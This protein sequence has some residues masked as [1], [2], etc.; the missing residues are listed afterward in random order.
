ME[1]Q[2]KTKEEIGRMIIAEMKTFANC[3]N[4]LGVIVVPISHHTHTANWTVARFNAGRSDTEACD[5]ALQVIVPRF[6]LAYGVVQ[7]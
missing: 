1:K 7:S 4:A 6:Q 5:R 2:S 3:D